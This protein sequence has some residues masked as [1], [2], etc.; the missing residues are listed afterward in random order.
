VEITTL[1]LPLG[2]IPSLFILY[3]VV[4]GYEDK[5][6]DRI[7]LIAFIVGMAIGTI[8]YLIEG[9]ILYSQMLKYIDAILI[10]SLLFS[11]QEQLAKVAILN[12]KF[13]E[14]KGLPIYGAGVGLGMA[15][16]FSPLLLGASLEISFENFLPIL[17]PFSAIFLG[18][19]TGIFIGIGIKRGDKLKFFIYAV[20]SGLAF[21]VFTSLSFYNS[22]FPILTIISSLF[23]FYIAYKN[24]PFGMLERRELLGSSDK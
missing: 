20:L 12:T 19:A 6:K 10:F 22:F 23:A 8:L 16:T 11:V 24:L 5:F 21:W 14:K 15:S 9:M 3:F 2:I 1:L 18:C 7:V 13:F 17:L 4:G